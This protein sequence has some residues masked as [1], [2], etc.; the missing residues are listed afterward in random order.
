MRL[1]SSCTSGGILQGLGE[2]ERK[3]LWQA[4]TLDMLGE[5]WRDGDDV[6][7]VM[8]AKRDDGQFHAQVDRRDK[9]E[10]VEHLLAW[11]G[12]LETSNGESIWR[13]RK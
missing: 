9:N 1:S 3:I 13:A 4:L 10:R 5:Y 2:G 12:T 11:R 8:F 6:V 7:H